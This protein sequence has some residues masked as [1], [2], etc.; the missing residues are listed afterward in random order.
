MITNTKRLSEILQSVKQLGNLTAAAQHLFVSQPYVS[1]VIKQAERDLNLSLIDRSSKPLKLTYAGNLY[2]NGLRQTQSELN[3]LNQS[4]RELAQSESGHITLAL[5]ESTAFQLLPTLATAF[6]QSYPQFHLDIYEV[7]SVSAEQMMND[8]QCDVYIGPKSS[9]HGDFVYRIMH[10]GSL[11]VLVPSKIDFPI[12][13]ITTSEQLLPLCNQPYLALDSHMVLGEIISIFF[14]QT[15]LSPKSRFH[16][17]N[18]STLQKMTEQGAGWTLLPQPQIPLNN[19]SIIPLSNNL[20]TYKLIMAHRASKENTP[21]MT[22]FL[23]IAQTILG[24]DPIQQSKFYD[25]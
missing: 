15:N 20:I 17:Q 16:L 25:Y 19:V 10:E 5:S 3:T 9:H 4:M 24:I 2:L 14:T 21:E 23:R 22:A 8:N 7:P 11:S 1:R 18:I 6:L 13:S 12:A